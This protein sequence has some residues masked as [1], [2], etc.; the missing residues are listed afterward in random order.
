MV[1][2]M[3]EFVRLLIK[4]NILFEFI[5]LFFDY[6]RARMNFYWRTFDSFTYLSI[7]NYE[8]LPDLPEDLT[9]TTTL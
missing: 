4:H 2:N 9:S 1:A 3:F 5:C 7:Y 8:I 6:E